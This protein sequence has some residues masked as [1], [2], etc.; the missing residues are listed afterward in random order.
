MPLLTTII[1]GDVWVECAL[2]RLLCSALVAIG[3]MLFTLIA[4]VALV[5]SP[6]Q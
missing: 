3:V 5:V 4:I 1:A 6:P 2:A